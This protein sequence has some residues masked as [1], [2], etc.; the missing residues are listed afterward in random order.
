[1]RLYRFLPTAL[2]LSIFAGLCVPAAAAPSPTINEFSA[3]NGPV[4]VTR[5]PDGNIWFADK[6]NPGQIGRITP[7]GAVATYAVPTKD[8]APTGVASGPGGIWFTE[9][10]K[11]Q[12]GRVTTGGIMSEFKGGAHDKP[13]GVTAG[14]D[15][16]VWY[17]A[18]GRGGAI[19]RIT[20][21]GAVTEF[22]TGLTTNSAPQDIELGPDGNLWFT[23]TA[24]NRIGRITP[25]GTI[26]EFS[27]GIT[28]PPQ[29]ITTGPDGNLW[30]TQ[31]GTLPAI[32]RITT[33]GA[34]SEF[35]TGP[36][37]APQGITAG[38]DGN[39]YFTDNGA[40]VIGRVTPSG[41]IAVFSAGLSAS[42]GLEG[43]ATGVDGRLWFGEAAAKKLGR[44][45]VGP[46]AGAVTT[47]GVGTTTA[48]LNA[49]VTPNSEDTTYHFEWGTTTA[50]GQATTE[51]AAGTGA[52]A[53]TATATLTGLAVSTPYHVRVVAT[54]ATGTTVGPDRIFTTTAPGAPTATSEAATGV[55]ADT[56]TLNA[57]VNQ[58]Q[59]ATTTYH[60]D[61]GTTASYGQRIPAS[62]ASV[63]SDGS[64]HAVARD[65]AGLEPNT[66]YHFRVVATTGS[67]VTTGDDEMFT[68]AA[69]LPNATTASAGAV[70]GGS[71]TLSGTVDPMNSP[72]TY[73]FEWGETTAYGNTAPAADTA[74][75][76]DHAPHA[77][78]EALSGLAPNTNYHF[79]LVA[80][81]LA[82]TT[83]GTDQ[84]FTTAL[85]APGAG[86]AAATDISPV[87]ATLRGTVNPRN[88]ATTYRFEWGATTGYGRTT[89][90][91]GIGAAPDLSDHDV[92]AE[93]GGLASGTTYHY[94]V[95]AE[96]PGGV[97]YGPDASFTTAQVLP[98]S[99]VGSPDPGP[100]ATDGGSSIPRPELGRTAVASVASGT[101]RVRVPG[102]S[103]LTALRDDQAIPSGSIIDARNGTLVLQNAVTRGGRT[104]HAS[105]RGALFQFSLSRREQGMVDIRV[106]QAPSGCTG[107]TGARIAR[108][109]KAAAP[110]GTLWAKDKHGR[111]RT[112]GRNSV[113]TVRGTEWTTTETCSG[114]VTRVIQGVV[115]VK[116]LRTGR[117]VVVRAGHSYRARPAR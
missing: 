62:E 36:S 33:T 97:A 73:R 71:A 43:I 25:S 29:E 82:G 48:T 109:A 12:I 47:S 28:G 22:V 86:T 78:L 14:P 9:T 23:E 77:V 44:M 8:A 18:T 50:Y 57:V 74:V 24:G 98:V 87:A 38:A 101:I 115:A 108:A 89:P 65:L 10:S 111:Y 106:K 94:R 69:V 117:T 45:T 19:G 13:V 3:G 67:E 30:F 100:P 110:G 60:F 27:A 55:G 90:A 40:N 2:T 56:A 16:N 15:G 76:G 79:R 21:L 58:T 26:T 34:V 83:A 88:A 104:Q 37:T 112:H 85:V 68:T 80:S 70:S 107:R 116:N 59:G 41:S 5:G 92:A 114:T 11:N 105:F 96:S 20:P 95:V 42:A 113:A 39:L 81:S 64:D 17:T 31:A 84:V 66:T 103:S 53:R 75:G 1:M 52:S 99:P 35:S 61:W 51:T 49:P 72:T 4:G 63:A 7:S 6:A 91:V 46:T 93:I 102:T 32:G 54:N